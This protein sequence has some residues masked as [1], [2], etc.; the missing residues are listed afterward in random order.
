MWPIVLLLSQTLSSAP[1]PEAR[2]R[3]NVLMIVIDDLGWRDLGCYGGEFYET[4][5]I[6]R[7][8]TEGV[9]FTDAYSNGP[10]CA[11]SRA[12]LMTG[13][14][15]PRHGIHTVLS[16]SRGKSEARRLLVPKNRTEL[17]DEEWTLAEALAEVGYDCAS[18]GKWHLGPSPTTQG[19]SR[20]LGGNERGHPRSYFSP[21][22]NAD[23]EDGPAGEHLTARLT[24]EAVDFLSEAREEPFFLYLS[25]FAV[26]TPIQS[27]PDLVRKY[28]EKRGDAQG[29]LPRPPYAA[30]VEAVDRGIGEVLA[31]LARLELDD[32]TLVVLISDNGGHGLQTSMAPLRGSKGMLYEGGI[33]VPMLLRWPGHVEAGATSDLPIQ[34]SDWFP[35]LLEAAGITPPEGLQLD[36]QSLLASLAGEHDLSERPL[37]WHFPAYLEAYAKGGDPWRTTPAGALRRGRYKLLEFFEDGRRELYDLESDPGETRDLGAERPEL[38]Q[39]LQAELDSWRARTGAVVPRERNPRF[40]APEPGR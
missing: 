10:N 40:S 21:Y 38:L 30:L 24:R 7:F 27:P 25:Y 13:R 19:F 8:A 2:P 31:A 15:P 34:G 32:S 35:T 16:A 23:L 3:P 4:P 9:R 18:M 5:A 26:H 22:Q 17:A 29:R 1:T 37:G 12:S 14:V 33:R 20:N 36:G 6:D 39:S 28:E 11:P